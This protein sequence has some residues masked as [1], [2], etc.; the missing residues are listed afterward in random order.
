MNTQLGLVRVAGYGIIA[1]SLGLKTPQIAR[2][3]QAKSL[4]GLAPASIYAD[5]FLFATSVIYHI[6]KR[7][8]IRAYG[9]SVVVLVQTMIM[10]ALLWRYGG[11]DNDDAV[12]GKGEGGSAAFSTTRAKKL[13]SPGGG[14]LGRTAIVIGSV[15]ASLACFQYLPER[16]WGLLVVVSTPTIFM[17]QVPQ[18]AKNFRQ[19]HTGEL[20]GLTV[21]LA[22]IGS[23]IRI[24]TTIADLG[25]DPW[26]LFNYMLGASSNALMLFQ[27]YIY[28]AK[29]AEIR[30]KVAERNE[31]AA[32]AAAAA[33]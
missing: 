32:A 31:S 29:T 28:R 17:V 11:T 18:I 9:E 26:L 16:L 2:V 1:G 12:L 4:V 19:R 5:V 33:A 27:M 22:F 10:V 3:W 24:G 20:A 30:R 8:P 14:V 15:A 6:L 13:S 25:G 23:S 7:N 21:L